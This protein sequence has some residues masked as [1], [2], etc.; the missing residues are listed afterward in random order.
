MPAAC[1]KAYRPPDNPIPGSVVLTRGDWDDIGAA[2][3]VGAGWA[4]MTPLSSQQTE[5]SVVFLMITIDEEP[6]LLIVTPGSGGRLELRSVVGAAGERERDREAALLRAVS[7]RLQQLSGVD[8][9][10]V[11]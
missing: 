7:R 8:A 11:R 6:G 1:G 2:V 9:A 10:P 5:T 4:E 3:L